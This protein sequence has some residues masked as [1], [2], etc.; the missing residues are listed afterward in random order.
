MNNYSFLLPENES[1][2][3]FNLSRYMKKQGWNESSDYMS[4]NFTEKNFQFDSI[5]AECLEFKNKLANLVE[6]YCPE[7]M[8]LTFCI[9][10]QNWISVLNDI[11]SKFYQ[12]DNQVIDTIKN[13]VW[14]LKPAELNN[15]KHIKIFQNL[16]ELEE[17]YLRPHRLGG[18]HVLQQYITNPHLLKGPSAGHKYSIRMF[19]IL[20]NYDGAYL[21]PEGYFNIAM[22]PYQDSNFGDLRC[23]L[24]NEHLSDEKINVIQIPT[25]KYNLFK[26]L[27]PKIKNIAKSVINALKKQYPHSFNCNTNRTLAIFGFDFLVDNNNYVWL[28]EVNH[29]PCFPIT[30]DHP[31]Q[32][33]LYKIF[34]QSI[35]SCFVETIAVN[36]PIAEVKYQLFEKLV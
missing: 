4:A 13:L 2:T 10:D 23:H 35:I 21:Y 1:P 16:S 11:A 18:G 3:Y 12:R 6:Q 22:Q 30:D 14:I 26:P 20:T 8:P 5:T 25:E 33:S 36:K 27:Y 19:I 28:L 9:N 17:H 31:L 7:V 34:W 15:G 29:G 32:Q 24:T